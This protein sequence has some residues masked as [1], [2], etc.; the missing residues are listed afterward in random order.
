[1]KRFVILAVGCAALAAGL[2]HAD[3]PV[4]IVTPKFD[5]ALPNVPGKSMIAVAVELPPGAVSA[6]HR[7]PKSAFIY[8]YVIQG[9]IRSQVEGQPAHDYH[10][11]EGWYEEPGA[12]H[13]LS[14]NLSKTKPARMLAVFVV[15]SDDKKLVTLDSE[16]GQ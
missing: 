10:A 14:T 6:P 1:M 3:N 9:T 8:A 15:D 12:H 5:H 11:G 13:I 16:G 7:H 4:G 2:A